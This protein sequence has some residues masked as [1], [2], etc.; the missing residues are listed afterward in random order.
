MEINVNDIFDSEIPNQ[1]TTLNDKELMLMLQTR[2]GKA[3]SINHITQLES[4]AEKPE[5]ERKELIEAL[6]ES[7]RHSIPD[8]QTS[9]PPAQNVT[10]KRVV[11]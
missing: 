5:S 8:T 9:M 10:V 2:F 11:F 4:I 6:I 1:W 3:L 7:F